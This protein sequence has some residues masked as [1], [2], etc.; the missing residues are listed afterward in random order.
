MS[1][2]YPVINGF[3]ILTEIFD[4]PVNIQEIAFLCKVHLNAVS[5]ETALL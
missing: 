3:E 5:M 1:T 2:L 4:F